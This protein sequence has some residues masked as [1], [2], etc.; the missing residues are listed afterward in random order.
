MRQT[1]S[2]GGNLILC[3]GVL[4]RGKLD[5]YRSEAVC[6]FLSDISISIVTGIQKA[7]GPLA[8]SSN[9]AVEV[10]FGI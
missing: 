1:L 8:Q 2:K 6:I 10:S 4:E 7:C 3:Y 9:S 5:I